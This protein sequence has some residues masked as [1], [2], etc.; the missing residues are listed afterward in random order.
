MPGTEKTT[1]EQDERTPFQRFED[2]ARK[3][4]AVPKH[5]IDEQEEGHTG[6]EPK[7]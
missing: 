5:E 6:T 1:A 3:L 7:S 4:I 2:F